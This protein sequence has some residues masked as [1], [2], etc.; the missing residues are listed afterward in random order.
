MQEVKVGAIKLKLVSE[1]GKHPEHLTWKQAL[2]RE[3]AGQWGSL[4]GRTGYRYRMAL[5]P[6][7]Y[8][9]RPEYRRGQLHLYEWILC[10]NGGLITLYSPAQ[11]LA[12]VW[13][14]LTLGEKILAAVPG[15]RIF[16]TSD[17]FLCYELLFPLE[18]IHLVCQLAGARRSRKGKAVS[19][20]DK[21][22][23][24]QV[25]FGSGRRLRHTIQERQAAI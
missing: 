23:L 3:W 10:R 13:T 11:E 24:R 8:Y 5:D 2:E 22:R 7:F 16:R 17:E 14:S 12:K 1:D 19:E 25:G 9:E 21:E 18:H 15:A 4:A 6:S 20:A